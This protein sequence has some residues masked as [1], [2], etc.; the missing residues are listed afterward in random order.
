MG[1]TDQDV[2]NGMLFKPLHAKGSCQ[3]EKNPKI[4]EKPPTQTPIQFFMTHVQKN[5]NTKNKQKKIP[6][7]KE[8]AKVGLDSLTHFPVSQICGFF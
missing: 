7:S 2:N 4:R 6:P 1:R 8:K 3:F 5:N